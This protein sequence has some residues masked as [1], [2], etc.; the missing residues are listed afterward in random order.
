MG[1]VSSK[2]E[3]EREGALHGDFVVGIGGYRWFWMDTIWS[4]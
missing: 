2:D 1:G 3:I 4:H